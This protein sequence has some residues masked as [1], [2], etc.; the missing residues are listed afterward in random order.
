MAEK[1]FGAGGFIY[2]SFNGSLPI[3]TPDPIP[4]PLDWEDPNWIKINPST[5]TFRRWVVFNDSE[6][7][8][9][10]RINSLD[11]DDILIYPKEWFGDNIHGKEI[12]LRNESLTNTSAYRVVLGSVTTTT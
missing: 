3:R 12:Y 5:L 9:R 6:D 7:T 1:L 10:V 8:I 2:R 11:N 4:I